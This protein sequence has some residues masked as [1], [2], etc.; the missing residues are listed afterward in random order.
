VH[1]ETEMKDCIRP[2]LTFLIKTL[3][4]KNLIKMINLAK[5]FYG[6][7]LVMFFGPS[8]FINIGDLELPPVF[9]IIFH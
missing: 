4:R 6:H 5:H 9:F 2:K 8:D 7:N 3:D 1:N